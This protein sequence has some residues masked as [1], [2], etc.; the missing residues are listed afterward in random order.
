MPTCVRVCVLQPAD[1]SE[2]SCS[3]RV[4]QQELEELKSVNASLKKENR[5]L[6]EQLGAARNGDGK[7][8]QPKQLLCHVVFRY[9]SDQTH[10]SFV[11][12]VR[13]SVCLS[14]VECARGRSV[15]PSCDAEFARSLKVFYHGMTS[16]RGQLQRLRRHRPSVRVCSSSGLVASIH[17]RGFP[18]NQER[19]DEWKK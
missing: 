9:Y 18:I 16:V 17:P 2:L 15:R 1:S 13:L 10:H 11:N 5:S 14:G 8:Q 12:S 6:R 3:F 4:L 7:K 19:R